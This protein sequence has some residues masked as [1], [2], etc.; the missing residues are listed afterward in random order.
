MLVLFGLDKISVMR[1]KRVLP[2]AFLCARVEV[3][4]RAVLRLA[5]F[6]V[7][8]KL[9]EQ[10]LLDKRHQVALGVRVYTKTARMVSQRLLEF[11]TAGVHDKNC[12]THLFSA[13]RQ[14]NS[15]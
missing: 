10:S 4:Q 15:T 2:N 13:T 6:P 5:L 11:R 7:R 9:C 1:V 3:V 14:A 12:T 8:W